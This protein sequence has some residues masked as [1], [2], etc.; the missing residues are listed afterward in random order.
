MR[1]RLLLSLLLASACATHYAYTFH[2]AD[3]GAQLA[4]APN[5]PDQVADADLAAELVV[6]ADA[7]ALSL[8]LT[9]KTDQVLQ[10][11]WANIALTAPD[12]TV[13]TLRPDADLGWLQ[14]SARTTAR[15]VP[16]ALPRTGSAAAANDNQTF[17]IAVPAIVRREPKLYR[18]NLVAHVRAL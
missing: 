15:L 14:P 8:A 7:G 18:Y 6:D 11:D 5:Q 17:R 2:D 9:N 13:A 4:T 1:E 10:V 12:G 16:F 3:P